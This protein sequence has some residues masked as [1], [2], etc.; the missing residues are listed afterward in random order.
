MSRAIDRNNRRRRR[1]RGAIS[2]ATPVVLLSIALPVLAL[3]IDVGRLAWEKRQLQEIAD[4]GAIDAMRAFGQCRETAG[5]PVAA[6]QAS[7]VRNGYDGNLAA[8]PNKVEIGSVMTRQADGVREF[9]AG[10]TAATAT[11][12]RVFATR[13]VPFTMIASAI[14]PGTATLQVEAVAAR[15]AVAGIS[16]GSFAA[17]LDSSRS[18]LL[19]PFFTALNGGGVSLDALSYQNL[20]GANVKVG[21]LVAAAGVGTV[22]ELLALELGASDYFELVAT[23]LSDSGET[24]AAAALNAIAATASGS[25]MIQMSDVLDVAPG[26]GDAA[27]DAKLNAFDLLDVG[28]QVAGKDTAIVI[29]PLAVTIPGVTKTTVR[30]RIVQSPQLAVGAPGRGSDGEWITSVRTGQ[31]RMAITMKLTGG[32]G[33][34]G[35]QTVSVDLFVEAAPT[36]AHLDAIDCADASDPVHRV[37]VGAEPGLVRLGIGTYPDFDNSPDPVPTKLVDLNLLLTSARIDAFSDVPFQSS[38]EELRFDGPFVPA[39]DEPSE[40]NTQTVGTPVG[41]SISTALTSLLANTQLTVVAGSGPPLSIALKN[42]ALTAVTNKL[43]PVLTAF[44]DSLTALFDTLGITLGGADVTI[45]S[46]EADQ[47][48]LAR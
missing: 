8:A 45:V 33:L 31:V 15:E 26:S 12:V 46:L 29:D 13:A 37:V 14:L 3:A 35:N 25:L 17:R 30:M 43:Q 1:E 42:S 6:A 40:D 28:A 22:D 32:L 39:I 36:V 24:S 44:D 23:A 20:A 9:T 27:L 2:F 18:W 10:G 41:D 4:L 7:A 19:N 38:G 5:D 47:P 16:A 48:A 11:A 21:D 34:L